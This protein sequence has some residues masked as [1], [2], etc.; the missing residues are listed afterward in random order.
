MT[1]LISWHG[2]VMGEETEKR[3]GVRMGKVYQAFSV[4]YVLLHFI[5]LSD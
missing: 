5:G 1:F 4:L 2:A 3:E